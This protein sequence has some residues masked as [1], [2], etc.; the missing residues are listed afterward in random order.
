MGRRSRTRIT[1]AIASLVLAALAHAAEHHRQDRG[2]QGASVPEA[3]ASQVL[4]AL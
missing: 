4:R 3:P 1:L 2:L